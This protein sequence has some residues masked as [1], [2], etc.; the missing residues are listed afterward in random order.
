MTIKGYKAKKSI[1][2]VKLDDYQDHIKIEHQK[3]TDKGLWLCHLT[4][5]FTKPKQNK[6]D[7]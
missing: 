1:T 7:F 4:S 5:Y 2:Q 6:N 3:W